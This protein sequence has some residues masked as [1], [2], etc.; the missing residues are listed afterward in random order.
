VDASRIVVLGL[1]EGTR[2]ASRLIT[3]SPKGILG[4][5]LMGYASVN[6]R[7]TIVWQTTVG[8]W[9][10]VQKLIPAAAGGQWTRAEY[11]AAVKNNPMLASVLNL[12]W[13]D[14]DGDG[15][16]TREELSGKNRPRLDAI[17]KAVDER[18]DQFLWQYLGNL[19]SAYLLEDWNGPPTHVTLLK[20]DIPI[21]IFHGELDGTI[22]IEG[23]REAEKAF[24]VA[25]KT[26]LV[27]RAYPGHDHDLNWTIEAASRGGPAPFRDAFDFVAGLVGSP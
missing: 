4:L 19:S 27:V 23:V 14:T 2:L 11:E 21:A 16:V 3:R 22:S 17:L 24:Q 18:N 20:L 7:E 6:A 15:I 12:Y 10:N 8:P 26:N 5:V 25:G 1:S 9:R 13:L